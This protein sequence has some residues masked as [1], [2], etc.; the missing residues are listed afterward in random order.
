MVLAPKNG[1][2]P[3][4]FCSQNENEDRLKEIE[5]DAKIERRR[6]ITAERAMAESDRLQKVLNTWFGRVITKTFAIWRNYLR[7]RRGGK[8][9][10]IANIGI[11]RRQ[12]D[13]KNA[14]KALR[15]LCARS[16]LQRKLEVEQEAEV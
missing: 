13:L 12:R 4:F 8:S 1:L 10:H 3:K 5:F 6:Q 11:W 7:W 14:F 2:V 15:H 9:M 16:R